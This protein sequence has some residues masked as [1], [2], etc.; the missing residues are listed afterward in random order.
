VS[1]PGAN[2]A[3]VVCMHGLGRSPRDWDGVGTGLRRY[4]AVH[5]FELP[6]GGLATLMSATV[7]LPDRAI[8]IG[9]SMAGVVALRNAALAPDRVT[10][11]VLTDS[12]VPPSRNGRSIAATAH[13]YGAHRMVLARELAARRSSLRPSG[14][15]ARGLGS[16]ALLGVR[17][18]AFH[19]TAAAVQAPVLVVHARNDHHVP[20]DFALSA[21]KR[22]PAW[23]VSLID[24]GGHNAHVERPNDWL[25]ATQAWLDELAT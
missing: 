23:T 4:G 9:H 10:G 22:H 12:F 14:A 13:D 24:S 17:P 5:P 7:D 21:A 20:V 11:V 25:A 19:E 8:L 18:R 1:V 15:S 3:T 2:A 6:R 16:L